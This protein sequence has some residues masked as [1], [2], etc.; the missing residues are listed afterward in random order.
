MTEQV[1]IGVGAILVVL[2]GV[3]AA[4]AEP[5]PAA[6]PSKE[7][8]ALLLA[9]EPPSLDTWPVWR[10][11]YLRWYFDRSG[12]TDE[13]DDALRSF[14]GER[15]S[16][17]GDAVAPPLDADPVAWSLFSTLLFGTPPDQDRAAAIRQ[18]EAAA[19]H[20]VELAPDSAPAQSTLAS[21][22]VYGLLM[23]PEDGDPAVRQRLRT[24]AEAAIAA[25]S[26]LSSDY[27]SRGSWRLTAV[28]SG[29]RESCSSR[30]RKTI[31]A[32]R[33]SLFFFSSPSSL[34]KRIGGSSSP[35]RRRWLGAFLRMAPS[36]HSMRWLS[37]AT[38]RSLRPLRHSVAPGQQASPPKTSSVTRRCARSSASSS[39]PGQ[40]GCCGEPESSSPSTP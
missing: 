39:P 16:P 21:T 11:R 13:M 35:I 34:T 28:I 18:A 25:T 30:A 26:R 8:I 20:A 37:L 2:A 32:I 10:E 31:H 27:R 1:R 7:A 33:P 3:V 14:I 36:W 17:S 9:E 6:A 29:G 23:M 24:D 4:A 22:S 40:S 19:T 12:A 15:L 38:V 5:Q